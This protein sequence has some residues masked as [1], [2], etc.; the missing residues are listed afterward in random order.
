MKEQI[1]ENVFYNHHFAKKYDLKGNI[2]GK[3]DASDSI[4]FIM[5]TIYRG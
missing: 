5:N 3:R 2:S 4:H 1:M